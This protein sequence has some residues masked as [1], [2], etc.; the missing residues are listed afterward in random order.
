MGM[1]CG[2]GRPGEAPGVTDVLCEASACEDRATRFGFTGT[3]ISVPN[4]LE[5]N[6]LACSP[7]G[8]G[9]RTGGPVRAGPV[10]VRPGRCTIYPE[11]LQ[12]LQ[13][14][15]DAGAVTV[16]QGMHERG[17]VLTSRQVDFPNSSHTGPDRNGGKPEGIPGGRPIAPSRRAVQ[18]HGDLECSERLILRAGSGTSPPQWYTRSAHLCPPFASA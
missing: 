8:I 2:T 14:G 5:G 3:P 18:Q 13:T 9:A 15:G 10:G 11:V 1:P 6:R 17:D 4:F 12:H 7:A 16:A